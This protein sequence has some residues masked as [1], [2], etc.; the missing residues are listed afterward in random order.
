VRGGRPVAL[1]VNI[2]GTSANEKLVGGTGDDYINGGGGNDDIRGILGNDILI[3]GSGLD[4]IRGGNLTEVHYGDT[5]VIGANAPTG[6][7]TWL[8]PGDPLA[9]PTAP[10]NAF[11]STS[12]TELYRVSI[13]A[14]VV[15]GATSTT[16]TFASTGLDASHTLYE[17]T[18][19]IGAA[20]KHVSLVTPHLV[21]STDPTVAPLFSLP[22]DPSNVPD[23]D[24][25]LKASLKE[26]E[27]FDFNRRGSA[28]DQTTGV[29]TGGSVA[30]GFDV[31]LV[32]MGTEG[33]SGAP[34]NAGAAGALHWKAIAEDGTT[35]LSE[36]DIHNVKGSV[37]QRGGATF[38]VTGGHQV[39]HLEF[40]PLQVT[41]ADGTV[42]SNT[43]VQIQDVRINYD[44]GNNVPESYF[45]NQFFNNGP[46]FLNVKSA[47]MSPF[48]GKVAYQGSIMTGGT[49]DQFDSAGHV[50]GDTGTD[51]FDVRL[52]MQDI[53][54]F[55]G[56]DSA[57][58]DHIVVGV[59]DGP[60][61]AYMI[62]DALKIAP[63]DNHRDLLL[64]P[65][66]TALWA[67]NGHNWVQQDFV[68]DIGVPLFSDDA[69]H[70]NA[71]L[72]LNDNL[73]WKL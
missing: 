71:S 33:A 38:G 29:A 42:L 27:R 66:G 62:R 22:T 51:S 58:P 11:K 40:T 16:A 3:G 41:A 47:D 60:D 61:L 31:T 63:L 20:A 26:V 67:E 48:T 52:G 64:G 17:F 72:G 49:G 15:E 9:N 30:R 45:T 23:S 10:Q 73:G 68:T 32:Q 7:P 21:A 53:R 34:Y 18:P 14:S 6:S 46:S 12:G 37:T 13:T 28:L 57:I 56:I 50:I 25:Q 59:R 35:V 39:D 19:T 55:K 44:D 24:L 65:Q 43:T 69:L 54:D 70:F 36:G 5:I 2:N 4:I 1:G 8:H